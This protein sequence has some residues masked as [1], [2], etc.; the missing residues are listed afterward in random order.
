MYKLAFMRLFKICTIVDYSPACFLVTWS[1]SPTHFLTTRCMS[2]YMMATFLEEGGDLI[3][4]EWLWKF[5]LGL[6]IV[7]LLVSMF[8]S[9]RIPYGRYSSDHFWSGW[10]GFTTW[11]K[12]PA[13]LG[14][15]LQ[16]LPAFVVPL[17]LVLNVG[18]KYVGEFN[19]NIILL[20][21]FILHYINR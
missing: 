18:G 17:Y 14:W 9:A 16:E 2:L 5:Q 4:L 21:M 8:T 3:Y 15:F 10:L 6:G 20:G 19:P 7:L 1:I 11:L 12:V 13:R